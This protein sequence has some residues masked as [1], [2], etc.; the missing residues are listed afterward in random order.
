MEVF[1]HHTRQKF[2]MA[3][4]GV[5][6]EGWMTGCPWAGWKC[7]GFSLAVGS[8]GAILAEVPYGESAEALLVVEV[9]VS[10]T[11]IGV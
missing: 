2:G 4:V 8:D 1:L 6:N 10:H 5:S 3:V 9:N 7:I 11:S